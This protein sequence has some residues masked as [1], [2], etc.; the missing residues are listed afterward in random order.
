MVRKPKSSQLKFIYNTRCVKK[1]AEDKIAKTN[2][3]NS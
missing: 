2:R 3:N 1:I